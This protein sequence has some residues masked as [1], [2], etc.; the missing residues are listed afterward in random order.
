MAF[1]LCLALADLFASL[2]GNCGKGSERS[3]FFIERPS[4]RTLHAWAVL[5]RV[6][7]VSLSQS[8]SKHGSRRTQY[9]AAGALFSVYQ[10][11]FSTLSLFLWALACRHHCRFMARGHLPVGVVELDL[12]FWMPFDTCFQI[13]AHD[14]DSRAPCAIKCVHADFKE[15][16]AASWSSTRCSWHSGSNATSVW[17]KLE[18]AR[19]MNGACHRSPFSRVQAIKAIP[20]TGQNL[21]EDAR[22]GDDETCHACGSNFHGE[23]QHNEAPAETKR[24]CEMQALPIFRAGAA[25]QE[26]GSTWG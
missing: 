17:P 9:R 13:V 25:A 4:V 1:A 15:L 19:G 22:A 21:I 2:I 23:A 16:P 14:A 26:G 24:S 11:L 20:E 8:A 18:R 12:L 7:Q 5:R 6:P 10:T 3:F